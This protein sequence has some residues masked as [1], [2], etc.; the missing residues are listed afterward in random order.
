MFGTRGVTRL[1]PHR[2]TNR[3]LTNQGRDVNRYGDSLPQPSLSGHVR[4]I[5]D[6]NLRTFSRPVADQH[7][8]GERER[9]AQAECRPCRRSS[10]P[11]PY[12]RLFADPSTAPTDAISGSAP[13]AACVARGPRG[14]AA[15][16]ASRLGLTD[17]RRAEPPKWSRGLRRAFASSY[18]RTTCTSVCPERPR[19]STR[20]A[21]S[22]TLAGTG[23]RA[24]HAQV[25]SQR[26]TARGHVIQLADHVDGSVELLRH[27]G[28]RIAVFDEVVCDT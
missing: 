25:V 7:E 28:D 18:G 19:L 21:V 13:T 14:A 8:A 22:I 1:A 12:R 24:W 26:E 3:K 10:R 2:G 4:N 27:R 16:S 11:W 23:H 5:P 15:D 20:A 9:A 17:L 6:L